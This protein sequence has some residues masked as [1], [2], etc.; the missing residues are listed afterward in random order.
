MMA[1]LG[2]LLYFRNDRGETWAERGL[3]ELGGSERR[4][5]LLRFLALAGVLNMIYLFTYFLPWQLFSLNSDPWPKS[6][7][8]KSYMRAGYDCGAETA[9]ACPG[10]DIP[11]PRPHSIPVGP[12]GDLVRP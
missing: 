5:T 3:S 4:K 6:I 8:G 9:Y 7:A 11:V 12:K 1:C 2:A 10:P